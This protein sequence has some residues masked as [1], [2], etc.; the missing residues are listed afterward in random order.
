MGANTQPM[1]E[2][3]AG[4]EKGIAVCILTTWYADA[5]GLLG[6]SLWSGHTTAERVTLSFS[7]QR[8]HR[9]SMPARLAVTEKGID[10][11]ILVT[12]YADAPG[13]LGQSL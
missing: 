11:C 3:F 2:R 4:G 9:R 8:S 13:L 5:P 7:T 12:W 1:P 10:V 6:Q